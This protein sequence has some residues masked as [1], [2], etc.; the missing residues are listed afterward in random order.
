MSKRII[1]DVGHPAQV[2]QFKKLYWLFEKKGWECLFVAKDKDITKTL[3]ENYKL[4]YKILSK[5]KKGL[6]RKILNIPIDDFRFYKIVKSF[7]P[8]FILNRFSIHSAHISKLMNITNIA[9][10]DTEHASAFHKLTIPFVDVKFTGDSYYLDLGK[11]HLKYRSNIELFYLHPDVFTPDISILDILGVNKE[12]KYA[13]VRFVSWNA[14]HDIGQKGMSNN[15]KYELVKKLSQYV[16]VFISSESELPM[17]LKK[18]QIAI[19]P[20]RIHHAIAFADLYVGEGGTM[21]SEAACLGVPAIYVNSLD[22]GVFHEEEKFGLLYSFRNL[23]GLVE[24]AL[25]IV[26]NSNIKVEHK[27]KLKNFLLDKIDAT[28][29]VYWFVE[30]YPKSKEILKE[31]P[32]YQSKFK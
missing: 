3:L 25:K 12:E 23:E 6:I 15:I 19:P 8:D 31:N 17:E 13:I 1:F 11:N 10:S 18:Y 27:K 22:A 4:N 20:N 5:N 24:K 26:T 7:K 16:K 2:H 9:F 29:F 30:N 28:S 21:A 14:H 32:D